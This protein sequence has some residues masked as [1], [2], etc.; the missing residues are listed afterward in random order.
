MEK[1]ETR[2]V[3]NAYHSKTTEVHGH[4][5]RNEGTEHRGQRSVGES[6]EV[7]SQRESG[8]GMSCSSV[9]GAWEPV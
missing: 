1:M 8:A 7:K 3:R 9:W 4:W 5:D 6:L 2:P